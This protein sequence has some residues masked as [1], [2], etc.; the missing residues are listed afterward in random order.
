MEFFIN[1]SND[2]FIIQIR[3]RHNRSRWL[4]SRIY[5]FNIWRIRIFDYSKIENNFQ[6]G[7]IRVSEN[8]DLSFRNL[9]SLFS[10]TLKWTFKNIA[11]NFDRILKKIGKKYV[12]IVFNANTTYTKK[13]VQI[14]WPPRV[15]FNGVPLRRK[16]RT[17]VSDWS[18]FQKIR[19]NHLTHPV[20]NSN[21]FQ[22]YRVLILRQTHE[23]LVNS[24]HLY[25][26][27]GYRGIN[28]TKT[29]PV[30]HVER[31]FCFS[32]DKRSRLPFRDG[33]NTVMTNT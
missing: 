7:N 25:Y 16:T 5:K 30:R 26:C 20:R 17:T 24:V 27:E 12:P 10:Q 23:K 2:F 19:P 4:Q 15:T 13:F 31:N 28:N 6:R 29:S 22:E 18:G 1:Y 8:H 32:R 14:I 21:S 33:I 3:R 11:N 9:N